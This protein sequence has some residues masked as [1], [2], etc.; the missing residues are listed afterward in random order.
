[1]RFRSGLSFSVALISSD[2][3][4]SWF[5]REHRAAFV[6]QQNLILLEIERIQEEQTN[7]GLWFVFCCGSVGIKLQVCGRFP[8][9]CHVPR[10]T[11]KLRLFLLF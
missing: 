9:L 2:S 5:V 3:F 11:L 8:L 1:M 4:I 6:W 10:E 7:K